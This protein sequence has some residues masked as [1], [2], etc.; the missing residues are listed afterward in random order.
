M[1]A[2]RFEIVRTDAPQPWHARVIA[3]NGKKRWVTENYTHRRA[4]VA[5]ID[6]LAAIFYGHVMDD[7]EGV[8]CLSA[9]DSWNKTSRAVAEIREIDERQPS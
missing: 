3:G 4:A 2:A 5:A 9:R 6:G 1:N 8:T 7:E